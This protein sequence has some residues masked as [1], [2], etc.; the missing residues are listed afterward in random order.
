MLLAGAHDEGWIE[1]HGFDA[2]RP[3]HQELT[4]ALGLVVAQAGRKIVA[5]VLGGDGA[6][7]GPSHRRH[8]RG[9]HKAHFG[10]TTYAGQSCRGVKRSQRK[11]RSPKISEPRRVVRLSRAPKLEA[12]PLLQLR[13]RGYFCPRPGG[14]SL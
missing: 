4:V 13:D 6:V 10:G 9:Q 11:D 14:L 5:H 7:E 2:S 3:S 8:R 12:P 1:T